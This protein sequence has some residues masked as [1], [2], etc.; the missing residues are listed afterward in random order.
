MLLSEVVCLI[1]NSICSPFRIF[2]TIRNNISATMARS[3][4]LMV[5]DVTSLQGKEGCIRTEHFF[6]ISTK[7]SKLLEGRIVKLKTTSVSKRRQ[8]SEGEAPNLWTVRTT[9]LRLTVHPVNSGVRSRIRSAGPKLESN[10]TSN[11]IRFVCG[12]TS[13]LFGVL[14]RYELYSRLSSTKG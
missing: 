1:W 3:D 4:W 14:S 9:P 2:R 7:E 6:I 10:L 11:S 8:T 12:A 13:A 5:Y